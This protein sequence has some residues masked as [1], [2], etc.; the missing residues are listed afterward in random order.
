MERIILTVLIILAILIVVFLIL[1]EVTCWYLKI[2]ERVSLLDE[3]NS[4]LKEILSNLKSMSTLNSSDNI[5]R[6]Q[7]IKLTI[8]DPEQEL[9]NED[10][11]E[12]YKITFQQDMYVYEGFK[13]AKL[14]DAINYVK[15]SE[16]KR[17]K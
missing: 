7:E 5:I 16:S 1:R 9:K 17:V 2:N 6:D 12:K 4:V 8:K 14:I 11:M 15:L 10:L 3:Q 13:C